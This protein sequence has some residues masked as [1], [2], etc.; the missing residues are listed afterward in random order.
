MGKR[1]VRA[2]AEHANLSADELDAWDPE[3]ILAA[4]ELNIAHRRR[5]FPGRVHLSPLDV[6]TASEQYQD[7]DFRSE[8]NNMPD[9]PRAIWSSRD[10]DVGMY[11]EM[12]CTRHNGHIYDRDHKEWK[13][14][15]TAGGT[16]SS[17][18]GGKQPVP[19]FGVYKGWKIHNRL[20]QRPPDACFDDE[21]NPLVLL[22]VQDAR[23][24]YQ[25]VND[26][27]PKYPN[28]WEALKEIFTKDGRLGKKVWALALGTG[29]LECPEEDF[30]KICWG[31]AID[32]RTHTLE[33][34]E[35]A[36]ALAMLAAVLRGA[37]YG[38]KPQKSKKP[39]KD[40]KIS[41]CQG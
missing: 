34:T 32:N 31:Y 8:Y 39:K 30:R 9:L 33:L 38:Q 2:R 22:F 35:G 13:L 24:E 6:Y 28:Y 26:T 23:G 15:D 21:R 14:L 19:P 25:L 37:G 18:P 12:F 41:G 27:L 3:R 10:D 7:E 5:G 40:P 36:D 11:T 17:P 1:M 16:L 4:A 20:H 29:S